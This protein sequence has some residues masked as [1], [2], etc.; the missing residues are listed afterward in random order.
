MYIVGTNKLSRWDK[1]QCTVIFNPLSKT[2]QNEIFF[3]IIFW[4][5][6]DLLFVLMEI[7]K[8]TN[9]KRCMQNYTFEKLSIKKGRK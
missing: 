9:G 5:D 2:F 4:A 6:I 8:N 1:V 3:V 7:C